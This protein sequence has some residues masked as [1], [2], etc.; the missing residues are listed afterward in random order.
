MRKRIF[1]LFFLIVTLVR[2]SDNTIPNLSHLGWDHDQEFVS[3]KKTLIFTSFSDSFQELLK[4]PLHLAAV[5]NRQDIVQHCI[6]VEKCDVDL[7]N[8]QGNTALMFAAQSGHADLIDY[9]L[10]KGAVIDQQGV[11]KYTAL[12]YAMDDLKVEA[13]KTLLKRGAVMNKWDWTFI[14]LECVRVALRYFPSVPP[15][16]DFHH[17]Y[18]LHELLLYG[19]HYPSN[20]VGTYSPILASIIT[21]EDSSQDFALIDHQKLDA[22]DELGN[23]PLFYAATQG[24]VKTVE[25]LLARG[26]NIFKLNKNHHHVL[27]YV[28]RITTKRSD[29]PVEERKNYENIEKLLHEPTCFAAFTLKPFPKDLKAVIKQHLYNHHN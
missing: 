11:R 14:D 27:Q 16:L 20:K 24:R 23:T 1:L 15:G 6:E 2:A 29:V 13:V 5:C 22:A 21:K 8:I 26:V 17:K 28:N 25:F 3:L 9:L 7:P 4:H 10:D 18:V 19:A 12:H